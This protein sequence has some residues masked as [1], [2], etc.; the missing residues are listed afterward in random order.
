[1]IEP[2]EVKESARSE[3]LRVSHATNARSL[4]GAINQAVKGIAIARGYV[5]PNGVDLKA[6]PTFS[7]Q[8]INGE[9]KT[10]VTFLV[11]GE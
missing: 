5:T 3:V 2:S 7:E 4:A 6:I 9:L 10:S 1:M 11:L 8:V